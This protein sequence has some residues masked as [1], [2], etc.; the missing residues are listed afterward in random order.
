MTETLMRRRADAEQRFEEAK[1]GI[2]AALLDGR[3]EEL[4]RLRAQRDEAMRDADELCGA[5]D[6]AAERERRAQEEAEA[7]RRRGHTARARALADERAG[8]AAAV[9]AALAALDAAAAE[10]RRLGDEL[11]DELR[12]A[13]LGDGGRIARAAKQN[14]RW[15]AWNSAPT[16]AELMEVPFAQSRRRAPLAELDAAAVPRIEEER[17]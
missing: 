11:A 6:L 2:P 16:A 1:R 13:G 15:A 14:M 17:T 7:Q 12:L 4:E 10:H 8:A 5:I 3:D 9:D